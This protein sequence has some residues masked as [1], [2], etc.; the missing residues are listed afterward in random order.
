M[1][2]TACMFSLSACSLCKK[3]VEHA[4]CEKTGEASAGAAQDTAVPSRFCSPR[5]ERFALATLALDGEGRIL[6]C[7]RA[8]EDN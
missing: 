1:D 7:G 8:D 2:L 6:K 3:L 5:T 4:R